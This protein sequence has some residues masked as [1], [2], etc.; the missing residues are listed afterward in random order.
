MYIKI[1]NYS[2]PKCAKETKFSPQSNFNMNNSILGF[3]SAKHDDNA[4][5][6]TLFIGL[7]RLE[8]ENIHFIKIY[9]YIYQ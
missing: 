8:S 4:L 1:E 7:P 9:I 5:Y 6:R 2:C 3:I